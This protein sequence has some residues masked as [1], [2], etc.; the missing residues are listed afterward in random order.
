M[1]RCST[2]KKDQLSPE[3]LARLDKLK[4][5]WDPLATQW[6]EGFE[7]LQAFVKKYKHCRVPISYKSRD[8]YPLGQ[9]VGVQRGRKD[10]LSPERLA[11]LEKLR[12]EW[13]P[14]ATQWEEGF[15][16]LQAFVKK[17]KCSR[18]GYQYQSPDGYPLGRW[19]NGQRASKDRLLP[20]RIAR[21]DKLK[22]DWDA[23]SKRE[24]VTQHARDLTDRQREIAALVCA[25]HPSKTIARKLRISEGTMHVRSGHDCK[26]WYLR[27][28]IDYL[29]D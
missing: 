8:G 18:V 13:N 20:E 22:F 9:W 5:D 11:R 3:R 24:T 7:H 16:H 2:R 28:M 26:R 29:V 17:Y 4:F 12:F 1:G 21:L 23:Q 10:R 19:V 6:E 14:I 15:E 27:P 25:G